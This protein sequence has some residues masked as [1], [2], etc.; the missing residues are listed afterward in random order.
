MVNSTD[1]MHKFVWAICWFLAQTTRNQLRMC[2]SGMLDGVVHPPSLGIG[3]AVCN[4][5]TFPIG[6][7]FDRFAYF[8]GSPL[9]SPS[10]V[11]LPL[12]VEPPS[13]KNSDPPGI[14]ALATALLPGRKDNLPPASGLPDKLVHRTGRTH[15]GQCGGMLGSQHDPWFLEMS[16]YHPD[17]Y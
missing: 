7:P 2:L 15:A 1:S 17:H 4:G 6:S 12:G 14:A 5:L 11:P 9:P 16:P 10:P 3:L 13:P 8:F